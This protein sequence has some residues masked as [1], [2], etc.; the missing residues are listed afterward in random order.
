MQYYELTSTCYLTKDIVFSEANETIGKK[1]NRSMV[2]DESLKENHEKNMYKHYVYNSFYPLEIKKTYKSGRIYVMKLRSLDNGFISK[3]SNLITRTL[4][5]DFKVIAVEQR[6][7]KQ[8][9]ITELYTVT[10]A[11]IT[12]NNRYWQIGDNFMLLQDRFQM[13]LEKKYK[14][15]YGEEINIDHS[16]I[17]S[18]E[19]L[20]KKPV[21]LKYKNTHMLG[22]KF[23]ITINDDELSQKLAFVAEATGIGEKGSSMG[24]GYCNAQYLK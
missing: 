13:N 22:N 3:M 24:M 10:P 17:Q 16:F 7:I 9:H 5:D 6:T 11:L 12:V 20:N 4:G 23:R 15:F 8:R 19:I 14:A 21:V 18:I 1:I 2:L